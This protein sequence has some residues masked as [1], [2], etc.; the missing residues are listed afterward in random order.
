MGFEL[1]MPDRDEEDFDDDY[2]DY[3]IEV[4]QPVNFIK[5]QYHEFQKTNR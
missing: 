5:E 3:I 2:L 4:L 1:E